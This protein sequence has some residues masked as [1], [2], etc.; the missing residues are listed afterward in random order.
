MTTEDPVW[1]SRQQLAD[2]WL[3]P[4]SSLAQWAVKGVGPRYATFGRSVRYLLDDVIAY[5]QSLLN[6][7]GGQEAS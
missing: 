6:G 7:R 2:R 4:K 5:E 3:K 1:L